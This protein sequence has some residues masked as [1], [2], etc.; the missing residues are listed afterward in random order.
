M[1]TAH[2]GFNSSQNEVTVALHNPIFLLGLQRSGTNFAFANIATIPNVQSYND[3]RAEV[4]DSY[5]LRDFGTIRKVICA[6]K[7]N[8]VAFKSISDTLRLPR[9]VQEFPEALFVVLYRKPL[10]IVNSWL[11]EFS[12][13]VHIVNH[14]I[15]FDFFSDRLKTATGIEWELPL[16]SSILDKYA[17][18]FSSVSD[19]ANKVALYWLLFHS[20]LIE[21][22][23]I[24]HPSVVTFSYEKITSDPYEFRKFVV[25]KCGI[26]TDGITVPKL[27][28]VYRRRLFFSERVARELIDEC[29]V[30][31]ETL[32]SK[33]R[34]A[35]E[36]V[37]L[38]F[39]QT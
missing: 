13:D 31:Y 27:P 3:D 25:E 22:K 6:A 20:F 24:N 10:E 14:I 1:N 36:G 5:L 35:A 4:F 19:Y 23:I 29:N 17:G 39:Q 8:I 7:P 9:L 21:T 34:A 16:V 18:R 2:L 30:V 38:P 32:E 37:M 12:R 33:R 11:Y 28:R 26:G 15:N